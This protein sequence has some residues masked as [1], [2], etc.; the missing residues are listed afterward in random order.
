MVL[1]A[2]RRLPQGARSERSTMFKLLKCFLVC[3][4]EIAGIVT[5]LLVE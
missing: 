4:L 1:E 3:C 2:E 5:T